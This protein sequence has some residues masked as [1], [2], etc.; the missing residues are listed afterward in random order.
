MRARRVP[1]GVTSRMRRLAGA[2]RGSTK[3]VTRAAVASP[4]MEYSP[5][6]ASPGKPESSSEAKPQ[7]EVSTPSRTVGQNA[8]TQ[9]RS[10]RRPPCVY[11]ADCTNR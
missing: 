11:W 7:I 9:A 6:W 4:T 5:N 1:S 2:S 10:S 3:R 8:P